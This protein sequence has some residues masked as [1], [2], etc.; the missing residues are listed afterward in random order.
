MLRDLADIR[1]ESGGGPFT[2]NRAQ[3]RINSRKDP[4]ASVHGPGYRAIYD[5]SDLSGSMFAVATGQSGNPL[6]SRYADTT[7]AWRDGKYIKI[8]QT[9]RGALEQTMGITILAPVK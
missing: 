1:I 2:V 4:F 3:P 8:P 5:L 9:R 7:R 6:S